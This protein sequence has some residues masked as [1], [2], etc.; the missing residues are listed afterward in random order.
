MPDLAG[1]QH[2]PGAGLLGIRPA[3]AEHKRA[4]VLVGGRLPGR[5]VAVA[6]D[7]GESRRFSASVTP[8]RIPVIVAESQIAF[9]AS[10]PQDRAICA[11]DWMTAIVTTPDPPYAGTYVGSAG[12]GAQFAIS[13]STNVSGG[14]SRDLGE[15]SARSFAVQVMSATRHCKSREAGSSAWASRYMVPWSARKSPG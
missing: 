8:P 1:G 9:A 15:W 10:L 4:F 12:N 5:L 13:P 14:S 6:G 2:R 11:R 3:G 7:G